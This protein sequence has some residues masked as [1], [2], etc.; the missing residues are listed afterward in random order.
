MENTKFQNIDQYIEIF[1]PAVQEKLE[2]VRQAIKNA[3]PEAVEGISYNIPTFKF[4]GNVTHFAGYKNHIGFYPG[5]KAIETFREKLGQF[6]TSK[7]AIQFPV[8]QPMPCDLIAEITEFRVNV[9]LEK[10]NS[11]KSK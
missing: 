4:H 5:S 7:G 11:A 6:K 1:P 2:E 10:R 3:A 8:D 9:N